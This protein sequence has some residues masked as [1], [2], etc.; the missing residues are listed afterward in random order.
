MFVVLIYIW[1]LTVPS[2]RNS[3][4]SAQ[5]KASHK[6]VSLPEKKKKQE[7]MQYRRW[8]KVVCVSGN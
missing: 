2:V 7:R 4:A 5:S 3:L 1:F 8:C 6:L